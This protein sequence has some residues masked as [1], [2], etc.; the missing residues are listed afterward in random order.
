LF[1][2]QLGLLIAVV[3]SPSFAVVS[4]IIVGIVVSIIEHVLNRT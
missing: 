1:A 4:A 2:L 3:V